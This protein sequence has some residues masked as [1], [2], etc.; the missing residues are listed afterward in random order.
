MIDLPNEQELKELK[1]FNEPGSLTIY[2]S[3]S[4]TD[5]TV[6]A[7][8]VSLKN[9]LKKTATNLM[10]S[11]GLKAYYIETTIKPALSIIDNPQFLPRHHENL[12]IFMHPDFFRYYHLPS[13]P[14]LDQ[15]SVG[16]GFDTR[17]LFKVMDKNRSYFVLALGHKNVYL[18][19]G[20][21]FKLRK[22]H[23]KGFPSNM[24]EALGIDEYPNWTEA[25][26][27]GPIGTS[28]ASEGFHG[29][30]NEAET[31]KQMLLE[32]F[33]RIDERL[34]KY[35][36]QKGIPLVIA[37]VNYLLPIYRRANT[38]GNLLPI[39][40]LGNQENVEPADIVKKAWRIVKMYM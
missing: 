39:G 20:D 8:R 10:E 19:R 21:R 13:K 15:V 2:A 26:P 6:A 36:N 29:Q 38:Y 12:V 14:S 34:H 17:P 7:N 28:Q 22:V 5:A 35:L 1:E 4:N 25:H 18:Y 3:F 27:V 11:V 24:E 37:G 40:I 30:Y 33:R 31:D 23:L 9:T 32:F 16:K